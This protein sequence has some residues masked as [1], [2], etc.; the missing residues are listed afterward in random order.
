MNGDICEDPMAQ[1]NGIGNPVNMEREQVDMAKNNI[2]YETAI[3][4]ITKKFAM[5]RAI[6]DGAR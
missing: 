4:A 3:K 5:T 2:A 1:M 6:L